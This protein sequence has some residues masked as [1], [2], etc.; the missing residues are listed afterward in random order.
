MAFRTRGSSRMETFVMV[1][2]TTALRWGFGH[3][4]VKTKVVSNTLAYELATEFSA[5]YT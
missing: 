3:F 2:K 5:W 1:S 4:N